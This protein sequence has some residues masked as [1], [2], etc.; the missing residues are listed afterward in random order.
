MPATL[1]IVPWSDPLVDATGHD[2]R[3]VYAEMF[4]LP[5]LGPTALL[6]LRHLAGRFDRSPGGLDLRV[7]DA[8]RALGVGHRDGA[9]SPINRTLARLE[10]FDL[11]CSDDGA[12]AMAV[13]RLLPAVPARLLRRLPASTQE[14][15]TRWFEGPFAD[16]RQA[17]ARERAQAL[18]AT[19]VEQGVDPGRIEA[20]VGANG[21]HPAV[22]AHAARW[23]REHVTGAPD[24]TA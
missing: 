11:A 7:V 23:I 22:S 9:S 5:T 4:W 21:F 2:P 19:L 13:R 24:T 6:L 3:S 15:H 12:R 18:A 8:S 1:T 20:A 10:Q 14:A 16:P 17:H